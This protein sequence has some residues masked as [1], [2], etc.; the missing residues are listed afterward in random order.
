MSTQQLAVPLQLRPA[1]APL[2][3]LELARDCAA[4]VITIR[5]ELDISTA[6]L[7]TELVEHFV[8][9]RPA[10]VVLDIAMVSF[11]CADGLRAL[12][13]TRGTVIAAGGRLVL[14]APSA[15]TRRVL[16]ITG[17]DHLFAVDSCAVRPVVNCSG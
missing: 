10:R 6:H 11:F 16:T 3:C 8:T 9:E 17:T 13:H 7:L 4:A 12:I 14:R 1:G 15:Q 5:G 2:L